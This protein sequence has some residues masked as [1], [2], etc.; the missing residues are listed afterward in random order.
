MSFEELVL[1]VSRLRG[2][3]GC[4]WDREQTRESL[5]PFLVEEFHELVDALE[6]NDVEGMKEEL[7]D[8]LFQIV[9]HCQLSKEE[10][11]FDVNDVI[12]GITKKMVKRHPHVFGGKELKTSEDVHRHWVEQKE[13][14]MKER[15]SL[16]DR[17]PLSLPALVRAQKLQEKASEVGFDWDNIGDVLKKLDEEIAELREALEKKNHNEIEAEMGDLLFVMVRIANYLNISSEDAL[18]KSIKKFIRRFQYLER[19]ASVMGNKLS[20]MTLEEMDVLWNRAKE[21]DI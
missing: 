4:P 15:K 9:T 12:E 20:Q 6:S 19:Q 10:D 3:G 8:L 11:L 21:E 2:P 5:K 17:I 18:K 7:G 16:L 13:K 14:V 1:I